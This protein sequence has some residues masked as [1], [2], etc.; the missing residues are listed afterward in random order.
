MSNKPNA[1]LKIKK[2]TIQFTSNVDKVKF[3]IEELINAANRDVGKYIRNIAGNKLYS[4]YVGVYQK[5]SKQRP[6]KGKLIKGYI[7]RNL[8]YWARK[9]E[10]D[11]QIGFKDHSWF[12]QQEL[13][14]AN[15]PKL[16]VLRNT[17]FENIGTIQNIQS[18]YISALSQDNPTI[19]P[20][21]DKP[22]D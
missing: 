15:Y 14:D 16:A 11:L 10:H 7:N 22:S 1:G 8:S 3:T 12:T 4:A 20:G 18:Q 9:K 5:G 13:G 19:P 21:E 17:V 6:R 2:G